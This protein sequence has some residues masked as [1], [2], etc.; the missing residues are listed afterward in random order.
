[1]PLTHPVRQILTEP[2]VFEFAK[3]IGGTFPPWFDPSY[4]YAG[5]KIKMCPDWLFI[6]GL[7]NLIYYVKILFFSLTSIAIAVNLF[8]KKAIASRDSLLS[9]SILFVPSMVGFLQYAFIINLSAVMPIFV[10]RYFGFYV[11]LFAL[12]ALA[13]LRIQK[14]KQG[15][16]SFKLGTAIIGLCLCIILGQHFMEDFKNLFQRQYFEHYLMANE[17]QKF[18]LREGDYVAK[19]GKEES[20][21]DWARLARLKNCC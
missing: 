7:C 11:I 13:S 21:I 15:I 18:G 20:L 5:Y 8:Y 17:L 12:A 16:R 2:A 10:N 1:M 3:P 19:I 14:S 6:T 4:W 9:N